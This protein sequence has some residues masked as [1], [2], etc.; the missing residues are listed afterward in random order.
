MPPDRRIHLC[1]PPYVPCAV[2]PGTH[3]PGG[4]V[5]PVAGAYGSIDGDAFPSGDTLGGPS[6]FGAGALGLGS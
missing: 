3:L 5:Y 2:R 1:S 4:C 6:E